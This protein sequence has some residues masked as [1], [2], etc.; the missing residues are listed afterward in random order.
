MAIIDN[1]A[2][3]VD[4]ISIANVLFILLFEASVNVA[5]I[6]ILVLVGFVLGFS[7]VFGIVEVWC[8]RCCLREDVDKSLV[9]DQLNEDIDELQ[10][11][12]LSDLKDDIK[13]LSLLIEHFHDFTIKDKQKKFLVESF[14][15][16][17]E[18]DQI[19]AKNLDIDTN[20][21][22]HLQHFIKELQNKNNY[23]AQLNKIR[24][25]AVDLGL[26]YIHQRDKIIG[27]EI[28]RKAIK[29]KED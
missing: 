9:K 17:L 6:V 8:C 1:M 27:D 5:I 25:Q 26:F 29:K 16:Y 12:S 2:V 24:I 10:I 14:N 23:N 7:W 4:R 22:N 18:K 3:I 19:N 28:F 20:L 21:F 11:E 13:R 15:C